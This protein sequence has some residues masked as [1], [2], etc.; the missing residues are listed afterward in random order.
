MKHSVLAQGLYL[1]NLLALPG[2]SFLLLIFLYLTRVWNGS[3]QDCIRDAFDLNL[4]DCNDIQQKRRIESNV[5]Q[6][7]LDRSHIRSAFWLTL[8]GGSLV[9]GGCS[10]IYFVMAS[11]TQTW[12]MIIVYFTIMHTT[13]VMWGMINLARAMSSRLPYFKLF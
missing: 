8:I 10:S 7:E 5:S 4:D 6:A 13:F 2:V 9:L 1:A 11:A 3:K 12:P